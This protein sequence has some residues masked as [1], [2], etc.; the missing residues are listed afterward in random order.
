MHV[1]TCVPTPLYLQGAYRDN[2]GK[3][4]VLG[5]VREAER[6]VTGNKFMEYVT[7]TLVGLGSVTLLSHRSCYDFVLTGHVP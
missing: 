7:M 2:D 1:F 5:C 3:P 6:R 4:V